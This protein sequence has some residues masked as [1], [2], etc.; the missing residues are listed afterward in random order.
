MPLMRC[1]AKKLALGGELV[2]EYASSETLLAFRRFF[3]CGPRAPPARSIDVQ[4][5]LRP[6]GK[7][8]RETAGMIK[9]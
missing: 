4:Y 3:L 2:V 1:G 6:D 9:R 5:I 7:R 8:A